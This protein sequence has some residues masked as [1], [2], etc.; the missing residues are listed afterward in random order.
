MVQCEFGIYFSCAFNHEE[1]K[2]IGLIVLSGSF[3][4]DVFHRY[5][6]FYIEFNAIKTMSSHKISCNQFESLIVRSKTLTFHYNSKKNNLTAFFLLRIQGTSRRNI[7][8]KNSVSFFTFDHWKC[9]STSLVVSHVF[10][11]RGFGLYPLSH[12]TRDQ[13]SRPRVAMELCFTENS[14]HCRF[15]FKSFVR[16]QGIFVVS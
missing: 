9:H 4:S 8:L 3:W 13:D 2:Y 6:V 11:K 1:I 5:L 14:S 15:S 12:C 16:F 7:A 10:C